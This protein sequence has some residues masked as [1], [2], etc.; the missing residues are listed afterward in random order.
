[1]LCLFRP[2]WE[3]SRS[4]PGEARA[5]SGASQ[6]PLKPTLHVQSWIAHICAALKELVA[7]DW[8]H[9]GTFESFGPSGRYWVE[10]NEGGSGQLEALFSALWNNLE[11]L[12]GQ[13]FERF[14]DTPGSVQQI[15]SCGLFIYL[16]I[17]FA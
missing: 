1:M 9:I 17:F 13:L 6:P 7:S 4:V 2:G 14:S 10:S 11:W 3:Q 15:L 8:G 16:Y 12:I 5:L